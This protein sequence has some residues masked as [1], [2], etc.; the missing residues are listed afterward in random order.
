[1]KPCIFIFSSRFDLKSLKPNQFDVILIEPPL[2]EYARTC[3]VTNVKFWDWDKIMALDI[4]ELAAQRSFV[5]L[6]CGSSDGLD[7][8]RLCLQ[9]WGF[10]RYSLVSNTRHTGI[11]DTAN[12]QVS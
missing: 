7:L 10:R 5:F 9:N 8:G 3:G 6:W 12:F 2:E 1:M 11:R 4:G